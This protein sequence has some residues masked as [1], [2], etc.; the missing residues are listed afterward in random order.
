LNFGLFGFQFIGQ[1]Q[2]DA[3]GAADIVL[4]DCPQCIIQRL[5]EL[6]LQHVSGQVVGHSDQ[7]GGPDQSLRLGQ[8]D[9]G[10]VAGLDSVV[11][12]DLPDYLAP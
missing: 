9:E 12:L 1:R 11:V 7:Q 4:E 2:I 3:D 8:G 6:G 5:S 10:A